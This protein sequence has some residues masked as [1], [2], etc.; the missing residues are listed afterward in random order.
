ME[1]ENREQGERVSDNKGWAEVSPS[2]LL[3]LLLSLWPLFLSSSSSASFP[4]S[5][6]F[7]FRPCFSSPPPLSFTS[8]RV[9]LLV[10]FVFVFLFR[11]FCRFHSQGRQGRRLHVCVRKIWRIHRDRSRTFRKSAAEVIL[12]AARGGFDRFL[13][14][15]WNVCQN[16]SCYKKRAALAQ[17]A[18]QT[19]EN[20]A[21]VTT[22]TS[23]ASV[24]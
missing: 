11:H 15:P 17:V 10:V 9:L 3:L 23:Y 18:N 19:R 12:T 4:T 5:L 21:S 6:L 7:F 20:F 8:L 24:W 1:R 16:P 14:T 22:R 13:M 2:S